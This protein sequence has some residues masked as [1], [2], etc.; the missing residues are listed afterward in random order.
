MDQSRLTN[1]PEPR[2]EEGTEEKKPYEKPAVVFER[3]LEALAAVCDPG[4]GGKA[5]GQIGCTTA[6]S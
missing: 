5:L 1:Y 4:V 2:A 3:P 6:F